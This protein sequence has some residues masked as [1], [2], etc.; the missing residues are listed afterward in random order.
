VRRAVR[1]LA[2]RP[3]LIRVTI[4]PSFLSLPD[5]EQWSDN[6]N[7]FVSVG[8]MLVFGVLVLL[9]SVLWAETNPYIDS[10]VCVDSDVKTNM[11]ADCQQHCESKLAVVFCAKACNKCKAYSK[12]Y[13]DAVT[14]TNTSKSLAPPEFVIDLDQAPSSR[15]NKLA[16]RFASLLLELLGI[17]RE[18]GWWER[19]STRTVV[20]YA[21]HTMDADCR[22]EMKGFA[23]TL[24]ISYDAL[25]KLNIYLE[26]IKKSEGA[27]VVV[28]TDDG[29]L[30]HGSTYDLIPTGLN[31]SVRT[32]TRE[33]VWCSCML[34][35]GG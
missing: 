18:S 15:Y 13:S 33:Q 31:T 21:N 5:D 20:A 28:Q 16:G 24:H 1:A 7:G 17:V 3:L 22:Q 32:V 12:L 2:R 26:L 30:Y 23:S 27:G 11:H 25:L 8:T 35:V 34:S 9:P 29:M 10:S 19:Q 14:T 6:D 4:L